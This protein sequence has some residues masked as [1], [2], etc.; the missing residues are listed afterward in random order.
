MEPALPG[1]GLWDV[2]PDIKDMET[3]TTSI[4]SVE[5]L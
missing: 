1:V 4:K 5:R 3:P 2:G